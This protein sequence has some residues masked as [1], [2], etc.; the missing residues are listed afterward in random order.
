MVLR[1]LMEFADRKIEQLRMP[2]ESLGSL[3]TL[4]RGCKTRSQIEE[5]VGRVCR[6]VVSQSLDLIGHASMVA[7]IP[8]RVC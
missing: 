1:H 5:G 8:E 2:I 3:D 6:R 4:V 7:P